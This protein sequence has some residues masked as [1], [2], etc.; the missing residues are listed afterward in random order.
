MLH[1]CFYTAHAERDASGS[2]PVE[3]YFSTRK[4]DQKFRVSGVRPAERE[5]RLWVE[6][7]VAD[8]CVRQLV[9][10]CRCESGPGSC[11]EA[12]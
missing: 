7:L 12:R 9:V 2:L 6:V 4:I 11:Q 10:A 3:L 1:P 5:E 8:P